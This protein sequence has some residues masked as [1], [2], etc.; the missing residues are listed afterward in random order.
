MAAYYFRNWDNYKM[1]I[2]IHNRIE[3][4]YVIKGKCTIEAEDIKYQL[5]NGDLI[6]VDSNVPHR[7][8]MENDEQC[9]MLNVE[10]VFEENDS[11]LSIGLLL[12][13]NFV[14]SKLMS[15]KNKYIIFKDTVDLY[16]Y[17]KTLI[18]ELS[19]KTDK[20]NKIV[21]LQSAQI[22]LK[23]AQI[24]ENNQS[25]QNKKSNLYINKTLN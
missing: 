12:G 7:I 21:Y 19:K 25:S 2:H 5:I 3:I 1:Q 22:L 14:S 24:Y 6:L 10:F 11:M 15:D 23:I 9:R 4:M 8:I 13:E 17:L 18:S 20:S 16:S